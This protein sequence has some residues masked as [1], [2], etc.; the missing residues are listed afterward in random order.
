MIELNFLLFN[1]N[2]NA[3]PKFCILIIASQTRNFQLHFALVT[4]QKNS[5]D[6]STE[7]LFYA[8]AFSTIA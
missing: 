8:I 2:S 7:F 5:V 3:V 6:F 4:P 1:Y